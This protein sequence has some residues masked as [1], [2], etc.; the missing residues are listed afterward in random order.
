MLLAHIL[1]AH[2]L[3]AHVLLAHRLLAHVLLAHVLLN[4]LLRA[5]LLLSHL[6]PSHMLLANVLLAHVLLVHMLLAHLLLAH[7]LLAHVLFAHMLF[8]DDDDVP[9]LTIK[10]VFAI[11][12]EKFCSIN[13]TPIGGLID[14]GMRKKRAVAQA[15]PKSKVPFANRNGRPNNSDCTDSQV[16]KLKKALTLA[17]REIAKLK[18]Q[19]HQAKENIAKQ[20][21]KCGSKD[22]SPED[23]VGSKR[24]RQQAKRAKTS[25][26]E[27]SSLS[28]PLKGF[29]MLPTA[30]YSS[31][32]EEDYTEKNVRA[33]Y[34]KA[35]FARIRSIPQKQLQQVIE[36]NPPRSRAGQVTTR[37]HQCLIDIAIDLMHDDEDNSVPLCPTWNPTMNIR[38]T[39]MEQLILEC[40]MMALLICATSSL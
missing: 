5:H 37:S 9:K 31:E 18:N 28:P 24:D 14:E 36:P 4:N 20:R 35:K 7:M 8:G 23:E 2:V 40:M 17:Q 13:G 25:K 10:K 16:A 26:P 11:C 30:E 22:D 34:A 15:E 32:D 19:L 12:R 29:R 21:A 33:T 1:P 6:L 3:L 39:S 27:L 38:K